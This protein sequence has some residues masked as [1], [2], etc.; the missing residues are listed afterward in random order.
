MPTERFACLAGGAGLMLVLFLAGARLGWPVTSYAQSACACKPKHKQQ[1][2][3]RIPLRECSQACQVRQGRQCQTDLQ[4]T[5]PGYRLL[6]SQFPSRVDG[7]GPGELGA[8]VCKSRVYEAM[9]A[10]ARQVP[11]T[12]ATASRPGVK[13]GQVFAGM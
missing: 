13:R 4:T 5:G 12:D 11:G 6:S 10:A 2:V 8:N 3:E 7:I 9:Q 1:T